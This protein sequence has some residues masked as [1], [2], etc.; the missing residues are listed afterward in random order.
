MLI[1]YI[2]A[3]SVQNNLLTVTNNI[4][5]QIKMTTSFPP[6]CNPPT[7]GKVHTSQEGYPFLT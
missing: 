1:L 4:F 5:V 3:N 2:P 6:P 7:N